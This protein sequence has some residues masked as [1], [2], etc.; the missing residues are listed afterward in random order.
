M[1]GTGTQT[2]P[3]R[4]GITVRRSDIAVI[5]MVLAQMCAFAFGYG[6]L[7]DQVGSLQQQ[8]DRLELRLN[9]M[10]GHH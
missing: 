6:K 2:A 9:V 7:T 10:D 5:L 8:V 3:E 1:H 4:N